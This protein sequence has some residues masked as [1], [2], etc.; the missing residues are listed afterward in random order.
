MIS[1]LLNSVFGFDSFCGAVCANIGFF[2]TGFESLEELGF[3]PVAP[4]GKMPVFLNSSSS[5]L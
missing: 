1:A 2:A 4:G 5:R 3:E